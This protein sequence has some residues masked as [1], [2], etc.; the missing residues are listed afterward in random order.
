MPT[1]LSDHLLVFARSLQQVVTF[2]DLLDVTR[3]ELH[4]AMGYNHA[5]LLIA[6]DETDL[7]QVRLI[8]FSGTQNESAEPFVAVKGDY[9]LEQLFATGTASIVADAMIDARANRRMVEEMGAR[10]LVHI[11]L[12]LM[13]TPFGALGTGTFNPDGPRVPTKDQMNY[14]VGMASQISVAASRLRHR[15]QQRAS[16]E[17]RERVQHRLAQ[18]Q[19]LESLG[20]MAG[21][22]A[23]DF[24]NLLTVILACAQMAQ[25]SNADDT[26]D[27]ELRNILEAATRG[28]ALTRQLL[29]M[30]RSQPLESRAVD[31]NARFRDLVT[32]LR[33]VLPENIDIDLIE[34]SGEMIVDG[35]ASQLDQAFMNLCINAREAMP[36][37]GRLTI[38]V[39]QVL[40]N[41]AYAKTHPWATPGRYVL[42][43]VTDTGIG[44]TNAIMERVFEP[45]FTTKALQSGTG[46]GLAVAYGSVRQHSGMMHCYSEV[47]VGTSFKVYL[48]LMSRPASDVG[49][50][51][52]GSV[53]GGSERL[54][55]A[56]DDPAVRSVIGRI[57][58]N[59]GYTLMVVDNGAAAVTAA[60]EEA[61]DLVILDVIMPGMSCT[62]VLK[63]LRAHQ[64]DVRVLLSSGYSADTNIGELVRESR[65]EL[66][67]KPYDPD[68]LLRTVRSALD[69]L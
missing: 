50:K 16:Q 2:R 12:R 17:E 68:K 55:I 56:E 52:E 4:R 34:H 35:D 14:L 9:H 64:S 53:K 27:E 30:S 62:D 51:L 59:A 69:R 47:G 25:L 65:C 7:S 8:H 22:V 45:F 36:L 38:E 40:V 28:A 44:M 63:Q 23:H 31:I 42:A 58:R 43:T 18:V 66:L 60:R 10:T 3:E 57:L 67:A 49:T 33:R 46:L 1:G 29:A 6:E 13:D 41:G 48:P 39:E 32:M 54:L 20:L 24:N 19:R 15:E 21:G 37:G 5:W 61:F 26:V 11:P